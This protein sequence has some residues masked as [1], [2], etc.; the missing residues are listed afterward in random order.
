MSLTPAQLAVELADREGDV[1]MARHVSGLRVAL[2]TFRRNAAGLV[3]D[4]GIAA[5]LA[6]QLAVE[7]PIAMAAM[8]ARPVFIEVGPSPGVADTAAEFAA[9]GTLLAGLVVRHGIAWQRLAA[10]LLA[11]ANGG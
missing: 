7:T 1:Q 4:R 9:A 3:Q 5:A 2:A 8:A 11:L 10:E 6:R